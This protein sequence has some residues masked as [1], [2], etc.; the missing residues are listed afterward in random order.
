[1]S[2]TL[3]LSLSIIHSG[4]RAW[5][6]RTPGLRHADDGR[7]WIRNE[8]SEIRSE[9]AEGNA[10]DFLSERGP[11]FGSSRLSLLAS[12]RGLM[13]K[14]FLTMEKSI[15][16]RQKVMYLSS[17]CIHSEEK[18]LLEFQLPLFLHLLCNEVRSSY[19]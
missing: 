5:P 9:R 4:R 10:T 14:V 13:R 16:L 7:V 19:T 8:V 2:A 3:G 15:P 1:M 18:V 6:T 12:Q 17:I 11:A